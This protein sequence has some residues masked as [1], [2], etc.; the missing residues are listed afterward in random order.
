MCSRCSNILA[1]CCTNT[2]AAPNR[3]VEIL[4]TI[5]R[6]LIYFISL[7]LS[8][9]PDWPIH[10]TV[11]LFQWLCT[12]S[13]HWSSSEG[14]TP[15][16]TE[17]KITRDTDKWH[18]LFAESKKGV[19]CIYYVY[20]PSLAFRSMLVTSKW[21]LLSI[22]SSLREGFGAQFLLLASSPNWRF[23]WEHVDLLSVLLII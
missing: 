6:Y 3:R 2:G 20:I 21:I 8:P 13:G 4:Q 14:S 18:N 22:A 17:T 16:P 5:G 11:C 19:M 15:H 23:S 1:D 7:S 12:V 9:V 10:C